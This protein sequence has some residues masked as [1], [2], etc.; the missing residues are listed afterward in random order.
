MLIEAKR[1]YGIVFRRTEGMFTYQGWPSV[2]RDDEGTLYAVCSGYRAQHICPFGKTVMNIS[3]DNGK[4]WSAPIIINDSP[5]DD[6]DAGIVYLGGRRLLV[7]WF[8]HPAEVYLHTYH[9]HIKNS[10]SF[11]EA[12]AALPVMQTWRSLTGE[13]QKGGS[14]V[15]LSEDGGL[16]WSERI[17]VPVSSPHGPNVLADGTILYLGK[18]MYS[19]REKPGVI[20]AWASTDGGYTWTRRGEVAFPQG[21]GPS[22]FHEPHVIQ[23]PS[24]R[25]LGAIR[26]QEPPSYHNFSIMTCFSDDGGYTWTEPRSLDVSGS[27]PHL[28]LHSS[29]AVICT[30]GRREAPFGERALI[31]RDGGE[32]W[33][34]EYILD[35]RANNGDLGY[36]CSVELPDR[37]ILTV[38]YQ[39]FPGDAKPSILCSTWEI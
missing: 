26:T 21:Y 36:P 28:L 35:D 13:Q 24:G 23:L 8:V 5:L 2:C 20:A 14:Y 33:E 18:S 11:D 22:N 29:G 12:T 10:C 17:R 1:E 39:R 9:N 25:L 31:S 30:F 27:P 6:R 19:D 3:R 7:T 15:I 34:D 37:K 16:T 4:T 32:T 38:Y